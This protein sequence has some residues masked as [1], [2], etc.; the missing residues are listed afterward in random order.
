[1]TCKV[2]KAKCEKCEHCLAIEC[3]DYVKCDFLNHKINT[4]RKPKRCSNFKKRG[5]KSK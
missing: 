2:P 5:E 4:W 3:I 1:M